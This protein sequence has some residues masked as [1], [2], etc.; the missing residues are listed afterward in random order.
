MPIARFQMPDGRI[1]RFEVPDGT[2]PEQ[3]QVLMQ[4]SMGLRSQSDDVQTLVDQGDTSTIDAKNFNR[5][6]GAFSKLAAGYGSAA[7][8]LWRGMKQATETNPAEMRRLQEEEATTRQLDKGLGGWGTA[9]KFLGGTALAV[10]AM[11]LPGANTI[12]GAALLGMLQG[13]AE[14]LVEGESRGARA[15]LGAGLGS[16]AQWGVP[17]AANWLAARSFGGT[18]AQTANAAKDAAQQAGRAEGLVVT[19]SE[20]GGG[21]FNNMLESMGGKAAVK[22]DVQRRNAQVIRDEI[23]PKSV[24]LPGGQ[25]VTLDALEAVRK[26]AGQAGYAPLDQMGQVNWTPSYVQALDAIERRFAKSRALT[27]SEK[28]PAV[29]D[30]VKELDVPSMSGKQLNETI[31]NLREIGNKN[32]SAVYG[33]S[34]QTQALGKAQIKAAAALENLAIE[35]LTAQGKQDLLP[36]LKE[37]RQLIA[38]T[39]D[40]ER[41]LN[42]VTGDISPALFAKKAKQGKPL[43]GELKTLADFVAAFPNAVAADARRIPTPGVSALNIPGGIIAGGAAHAMGGAPAA[44][45]AA[46]LPLL[47]DPVRQMLMSKAYQSAVAQPSYPGHGLLGITPG[48]M[49]S[50][51]ARLLGRILAPQAGLLGMDE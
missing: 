46:G 20:A 35:N 43:S 45:V 49:D 36:A 48:M 19:P 6:A 2:T 24:G 51:T 25:P 4:S 44:A 38:K 41:S 7:P 22:Q 47:R 12:A 50:D 31:Q 1:A 15:A 32:A 13:A 21:W 8:S 11:M 29:S 23:A 3:A 9:G 40:L 30:M 16:A 42:Q 34:S 17:K 26:Q 10:P 37:A 33:M 18:A 27:T 28:V 14:P 39:Y 5:D